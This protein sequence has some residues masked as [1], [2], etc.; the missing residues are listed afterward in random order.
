VNEVCYCGVKEREGRGRRHLWKSRGL[1]I[2]ENEEKFGIGKK[3]H[4]QI[5]S[6]VNHSS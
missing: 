4:S 5:L 3:V 6:K 1:W 2:K